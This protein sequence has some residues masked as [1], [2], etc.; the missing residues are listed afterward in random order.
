[1]LHSSNERMPQLNMLFPFI[2]VF[3]SIFTEYLKR[4]KDKK[5]QLS[6]A[7][8]SA[9]TEKSINSIII[10]SI[11]PTPTSTDEVIIF[12]K[13][14]LLSSRLCTSFLC[15]RGRRLHVE[16]KHMCVCVSLHERKRVGKKRRGN[17][18][19]YAVNNP[20]TQFASKDVQQLHKLRLIS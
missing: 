4:E 11:Y 13:D 8:S 5:I 19:F 1:M 14:V 9:K 3:C 6:N 15:C 12:I 2:C 20:C 17:V 18:C 7:N 10:Y 16:R